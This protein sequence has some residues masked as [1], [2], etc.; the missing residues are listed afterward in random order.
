MTETKTAPTAQYFTQEEQTTILANADALA[1]LGGG[2]R[3]VHQLLARAF[4]GYLGGYF[5][6]ASWGVNAF[7]QEHEVRDPTELKAFLSANFR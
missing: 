3:N 5:P 2:R 6:W 4:E 7:T 1:T